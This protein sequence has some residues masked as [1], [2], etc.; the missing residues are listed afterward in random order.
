MG[1]AGA[2]VLLGAAASA[3]WVIVERQVLAGAL[4]VDLKST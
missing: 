4:T 3:T 1:G 2:G